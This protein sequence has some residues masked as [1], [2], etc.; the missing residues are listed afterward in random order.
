MFDF[1]RQKR[2]PP[3][4]PE[5][6]V[7]KSFRIYGR[8]QGVGFRYRAKYAAEMLNLTGWVENL[9]DGSVQM[10]VQGHPD[11][12]ERIFTVIQQNDYVQITDMDV[13][14]IPVNPWDRAFTVRA[15]WY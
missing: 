10:E 2:Q 9:D 8:V 7:R 12:I 1:L 3:V 6:T 13:R 14:E 5:G 11:L 4:L 15:D